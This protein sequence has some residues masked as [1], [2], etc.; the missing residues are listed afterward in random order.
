MLHQTCATATPPDSDEPFGSSLFETIPEGTTANGPLPI[1]TSSAH[2]LPFDIDMT[3]LTRVFVTTEIFI[4]Q[5]IASL[6]SL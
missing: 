6:R 1:E 5:T 3:T 4:H 2:R